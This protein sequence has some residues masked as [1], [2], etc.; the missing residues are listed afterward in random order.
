MKSIIVFGAGGHAKCLIDTVEKQGEYQIVG[1]LDG[2]KPA[3]SHVYGYE[4]LGSEQWL[5]EHAAHVEGMIIAIGDNWLRGRIAEKIQAIA[6]RIPFIS[7]IHPAACIARGARI[8]AGSVIMANAV[9]GSDA[10]IGEHGILYP[11]A[12]IDHD[13]QVGQFVS[14][15]PRAVCGGNVTVGDFS[16]IAIGASLI[17]GIT[18]GEH[19][20]IGAGSVVIRSIP[21]R[22]VAFGAPAKAI[23][24]RIPGERYL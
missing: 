23:R 19:S 4:I 21:S 10:L 18:I 20:V 6:P 15:A 9:L 22:T 1:L 14:W 16:A 12:S 3:G 13:S 24:S 5:A 11:G 8:G 17:H 7:A 2:G